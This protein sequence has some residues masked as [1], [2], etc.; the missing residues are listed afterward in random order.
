MAIRTT[1]TAMAT[2][3]ATTPAT[4]AAPALP[5]EPLAVLK[6]DVAALMAQRRPRII[7]TARARW[8]PA[9]SAPGA[10][11]RGDPRS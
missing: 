6:R 10:H 11:R 7:A 5:E 1:A 2:T 4:A 8:D 9:R 3:P